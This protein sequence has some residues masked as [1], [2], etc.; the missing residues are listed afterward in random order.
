MWV[1]AADALHA[2]FDVGICH[3]HLLVV[4]W[5]ASPGRVEP[6]L[7]CTSD[8]IVASLVHGHQHDWSPERYSRSHRSWKPPLREPVGLSE[9]SSGDVL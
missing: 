3:L 1:R 4:P 5:G 7:D 8:D 2:S 9:G 6:L